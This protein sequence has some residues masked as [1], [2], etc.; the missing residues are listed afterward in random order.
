M[1]T[2]QTFRD[3]EGALFNSGCCIKMFPV[4]IGPEAKYTAPGA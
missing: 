1:G 3:G 4:V 2:L